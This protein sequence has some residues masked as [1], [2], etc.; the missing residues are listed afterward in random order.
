MC[1]LL[2]LVGLCVAFEMKS[3]KNA[4]IILD[5]LVW[6]SN[7]HLHAMIKELLNGF[8]EHLVLKDFS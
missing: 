8:A 2:A 3:C 6:L 1:R 7:F 5:I 4:P